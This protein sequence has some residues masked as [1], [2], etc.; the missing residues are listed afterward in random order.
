M[1]VAAFPGSFDPLT[2]GHLDI[3]LRGYHLFDKFYIAVVN[4]PNKT[5]TFSLQERKEMIEEVLED[6]QIANRVV[7]KE[8]SGLLV[9]FLSE[10][11]ASI[12]VRGIRA[13]SDFEFEF[14]AARM[15]NHLDPSIET[16]F[17]LSKSDY[18][19]ISSSL[20]KEVYNLGGNV[21]HYLPKSILTRLIEKENI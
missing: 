16:L 17:L 1:K 21:S 9:H 20:I 4:N 3:I 10:I 7:V 14:R 11:K 12:I 6:H 18:E 15:N 5:C 19:H 8:F 2:N 13:L